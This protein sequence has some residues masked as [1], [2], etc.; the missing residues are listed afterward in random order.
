MVGLACSSMVGL[1]LQ[2]LDSL[3]LQWLDS[4]VLQWLGSFFHGWTRLFFHGRTGL[5]IFSNFQEKTLHPRRRHRPITMLFF[6]IRTTLLDSLDVLLESWLSWLSWLMSWLR[7]SWWVVLIDILLIL[8]LSEVSKKTS[9]CM[10]QVPP[11]TS[12][13]R[14]DVCLVLTFVPRHSFLLANDSPCIYCFVYL[15]VPL[16][17][18]ALFFLF[19][20]GVF[21]SLHA[22]FV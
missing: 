10:D 21:V 18:V 11:S 3:V 4:R 7:S 13:S 15:E 19:W 2:R 6:E 20:V 8:A 1:V 14:S 22:H 12:L 9:R 17:S 16:P 5:S